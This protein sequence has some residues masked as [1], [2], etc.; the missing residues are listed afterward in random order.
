MFTSFLFQNITIIDFER[1]FKTVVQIFNN[2]AEKKG[3]ARI[4]SP[5]KFNEAVGQ[6]ENLEREAENGCPMI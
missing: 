2:P 6:Y 1:L 3:Q 4:S 5:E